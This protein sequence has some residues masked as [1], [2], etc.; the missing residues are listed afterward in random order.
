[1]S[2]FY[3]RFAAQSARNLGRNN[4]RSLRRQNSPA[5]S[6]QRDRLFCSCC[7]RSAMNTSWLKIE[8][9]RDQRFGRYQHFPSQ[10][11]GERFPRAPAPIFP[12]RLSI[13]P[14]PLPPRRREEEPL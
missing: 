11:D 14:S 2:F 5:A 4:R 7:R 8:P 3:R 1:M 12:K 10:R 13:P 6:N 9:D